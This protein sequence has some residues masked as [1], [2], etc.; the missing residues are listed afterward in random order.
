[1]RIQDH[2]GMISWSILDKGLYI[3]FGFVQIIILHY[4]SASEYALYAL[5]IFLHSWIFTISDS[6]AL[7]SLI[8]FGM[9]I[10]NQ[11]KV[12]FISL[13]THII[14]TLGIALIIYFLRNPLSVFFDKPQITQIASVLPILSLVFVPK[15][16]CQKIIYRIQN[17]FYLFLTNLVFFGLTTI[18][19]LNGI[20]N[21]SSLNFQSLSFYYIC[22]SLMS[23]IFALILVRQHLKFGRQ[24]K[25][26]LKTI[27]GFSRK[28]TLINLLNSFPKQIDA[29]IIT[30]FFPLETVGLYAAAKNL[31]RLF[32]EAINALY[33]LLYPAGVK[34]IL[35]GNIESL[36][37]ILSKAVS[38]VFWG[39]IIISLILLSNIG[40]YLFNNL[41][42]SSYSNSIY[43]FR[44]L[45]I[46]TPFLSFIAFYSIL[47][48]AN[49]LRQVFYSVLISNI[50]FFIATLSICNYQMQNLVP[51]GLIIYNIM[52]GS[53]GLFLGMKYYNF[54]LNMLLIAFV[55]SFIFI[56][57]KLL[58]K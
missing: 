22:G 54:K 5:L 30:I 52:L 17:M 19:I 3:G 24:G 20:K 55:D 49:K 58:T 38:F 6:F 53:L 32:D 47:T 33:G 21:N 27:F 28:I 14:F 26:S 44:I 37:R 45:L 8:Q 9:D 11:N 34:N 12:N 16:F 39:F 36:E 40:S 41:F 1:M 10:E 48:A 42:P 2:I 23:S 25:I 4:T 51:L 35:R 57:S 7:Q 46:S 18:L 15:A 31:F 13:L 50:C 56:K 43:Y 29:F